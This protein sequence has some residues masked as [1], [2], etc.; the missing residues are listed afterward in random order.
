MNNKFNSLVRTKIIDT[1]DNKTLISIVL[2]TLALLSILFY[3]LPVE[4]D[5]SRNHSNSICRES[6][7]ILKT[8]DVKDGDLKVVYLSAIT[9]ASVDTNVKQRVQTVFDQFYKYN[10]SIEYKTI[11]LARHAEALGQYPVAEKK[12]IVIDYKGKQ[13]YIPFESFVTVTSE[14]IEVN[15]E[16]VLIDEFNLSIMPIL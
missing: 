9:N 12:S 14:E 16:S 5:C 4:I 15:V 13:S 6:K 10:K 11:D 3:L 1:F 2:I 8:L 7:S